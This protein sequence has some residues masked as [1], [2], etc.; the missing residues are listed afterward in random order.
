MPRDIRMLTLK[1]CLIKNHSIEQPCYSQRE[2]TDLLNKIFMCLK[3]KL[4]FF[5]FFLLKFS[6]VLQLS[7][8]KRAR[9]FFTLATLCHFTISDGLASELLSAAGKLPASLRS[10]IGFS[11]PSWLRRFFSLSALQTVDADFYFLKKIQP[12]S[13]QNIHDKQSMSKFPLPIFTIIF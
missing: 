2:N 5:F 1:L 13:K 9:L 11:W 8:M 4:L 3:G 6:I 12:I 10:L 7:Q